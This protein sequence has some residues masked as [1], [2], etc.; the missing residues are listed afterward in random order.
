MTFKPHSPSW[1]RCNGTV[2]ASEPLIELAAAEQT[3]NRPYVLLDDQKSNVGILLT[4]AAEIL[5]AQHADEVPEVLDRA[6]ALADSG[7]TLAGFLSFRSGAAFDR[8]EMQ[9]ATLG[10]CPTPCLW[11]AAFN[12]KITGVVDRHPPPPLTP[13]LVPRICRAEYEVMID[14][15]LGHIRSGDIYQVNLTFPIM[16][17]L[18]DSLAYYR[19][20]RAAAHGP[21]G[22]IVETGLETI[23]SFSPE[24]FFDYDDGRLTARPMKGTRPRA[25][26][27]GADQAAAGDLRE[28]RKDKAENLMIVDL[29]R[30][31]MARICEAGSITVP[32]LF[33]IESY[34]TVWQMTSTV[35]GTPR[36]DVKLSS[37]LRAL[38]PCGSITGAP[39][40]MA[41]KII[42]SIERWD[43][44]AYTGSIGWFGKQ[45][46]QMNVAIRTAQRAR[47]A[48]FA[49]IDVGAGIV[50]DSVPAAEWAECL[51]K[52][53]FAGS[54]I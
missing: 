26:D 35:T 38:F 50:A 42:A 43:R 13:K 7:A 54:V 52:S 21:Y 4:D 9:K 40:I 25:A 45:S 46:A 19:S 29:L 14:Q 33:A 1:R 15:A 6:D 24:L 31:D 44:G 48:A 41:S 51:A 2:L 5:R 16:A 39:K 36:A 11:L 3:C 53:R 12:R 30:S 23:L 20:R 37:I 8:L 47:G 27:R 18:S 22:G 28:S 32:E 49:R 10:T 34:P 17:E